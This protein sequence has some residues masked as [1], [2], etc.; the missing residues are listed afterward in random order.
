MANKVVLLNNNNHILLESDRNK[1]NRC[2]RA[3]EVHHPNRFPDCR[4]EL[5][6]SYVGPEAESPR[7]KHNYTHGEALIQRHKVLS[8]TE[9]LSPINKHLHF[10]MLLHNVGN[11]C[12]GSNVGGC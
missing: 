9:H 2:D 1:T 4:T 8:Q 5:D 12:L 11:L 10:L 3:A 7:C 6:P